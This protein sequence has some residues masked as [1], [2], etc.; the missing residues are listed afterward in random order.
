MPQRLA[1][2][3]DLNTI[4]QSFGIKSYSIQLE[5]K[6][7]ISPG[8]NVPVIIEKDNK[9][10]CVIM[11]WGLVPQ[12][13]NDPLIGFQLANANAES[14][15]RDKNFKNSLRKRR[16]IIPCSGYYLWERVDTEKKYYFIKTKRDDLFGLA[17]LWDTWGRDGGNLTTFTIITMP[18]NEQLE[19]ISNRTG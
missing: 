8:Q 12:W 9:R 7:N 4:A 15:D 1:L 13:S 17:G 3:H 14:I 19:L 6:Y 16:C 10:M 5:A 2:Y 11:R 18:S